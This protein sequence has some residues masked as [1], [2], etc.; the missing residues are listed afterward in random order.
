MGQQGVRFLMQP[1]QDSRILDV[2]DGLVREVDVEG[3]CRGSC[4]DICP[5]LLLQA[6]VKHL[7]VK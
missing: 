1:C 6:L 4:D 7:H 3:H 2:Q 5:M